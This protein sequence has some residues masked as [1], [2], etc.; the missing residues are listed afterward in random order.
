MVF[1]SKSFAK[2]VVYNSITNKLRIGLKEAVILES[3]QKLTY[4]KN[5]LKV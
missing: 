2:Y 1:F 5:E 4:L 3:C